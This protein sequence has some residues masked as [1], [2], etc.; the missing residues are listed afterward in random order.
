[1]ARRKGVNLATDLLDALAPALCV[2]CRG[3]PG[4]LPW[5]CS[6]CAARLRLVSG[7]VCLRCGA[8]RLLPT[9]VCGACPDWPRRLVAARSGAM[10]S[11]AARDLVHSLKFAHA[12]EAARPLGFLAAAAARALDPPADCAVV[13]VPLHWARRRKRGFNQA[14][15]LARVVAPALHLERKPGLL[16]RIRAGAGNVHRSALGRVRETRGAFRAISAARGRNVLLVDDVLTTGATLGACTRALGRR[17]VAAVWA[18]TATR[19][20]PPR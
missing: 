14:A 11:G 3:P 5:L 13:P 12:L 6:R 18:V 4:E 1:L 10:H 19:A 15:E 7:A 16:R 17:G 9:P 8:P 20:P 2:L